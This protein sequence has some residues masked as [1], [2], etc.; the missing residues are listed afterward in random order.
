MLQI[1]IEFLLARL[2]SPITYASLRRARAALERIGE[3]DISHDAIVRAV[4]QYPFFTWDGSAVTRTECVS[5][6][7]DIPDSIL[8]E[9]IEA[10][11]PLMTTLDQIIANWDDKTRGEC[12]I[13]I[14]DYERIDIHDMS[15][16]TRELMFEVL[17]E[18][19]RQRAGRKK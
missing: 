13:V 9:A 1:D 6:D 4:E 7:P 2:P 11:E 8:D 3:V 19:Q 16:V 12:I 5:F 17:E 14:D 15:G 10:I 18:I